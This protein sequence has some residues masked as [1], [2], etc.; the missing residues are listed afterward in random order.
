LYN[1]KLPN[2]IIADATITV[3]PAAGPDTLKVEALKKAT[4]KPP[5]IPAIIPE[6]SG[7]PEAKAIPKQSGK[8]TKKT[9]NP[10][11]KS[12][13]RLFKLSFTIIFYLSNNYIKTRIIE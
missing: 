13:F 3:N 1:S 12:Y 5:T 11:G 9:T 4:I 2:E 8:A 7:A 10:A 6:K